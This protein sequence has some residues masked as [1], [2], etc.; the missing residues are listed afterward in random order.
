MDST[1]ALKKAPRKEAVD[2]EE[3]PG[4]AVEADVRESSTHPCLKEDKNESSFCPKIDFC[5]KRTPMFDGI[6]TQ[7]TRAKSLPGTSRIAAI[8]KLMNRVPVHNKDSVSRAATIT[9]CSF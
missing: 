1:T 4:K 5:Q 2:D 9:I 8:R 3:E 6:L 7:A